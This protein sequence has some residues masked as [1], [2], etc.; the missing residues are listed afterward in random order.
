MD[1]QPILDSLSSFSV[2]RVVAWIVVIGTILSTLCAGTIKLY[3]V[4]TKYKDMKDKEQKQETIIETETHDKTLNEIKDSLQDI[5]NSLNEQKDVNL[6]QLRHTIVQ[7][8]EDCLEKGEISIN[9]LRSLEEM[10]SEYV[11]VFHAN[12]YV[13]ILVERVRTLKIVGR[14]E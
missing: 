7:T 11:N 5:K 4:F 8:C 2:G 6:K 10:Y 9:R 13:K 1:T 14:E 3:K 12:G